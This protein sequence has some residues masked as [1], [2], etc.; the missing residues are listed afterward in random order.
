MSCAFRYYILELVC[1]SVLSVMSSEMEKIS[2]Q[3]K[4]EKYRIYNKKTKTKKKTK[5]KDKKQTIWFARYPIAIDF[6]KEEE[7]LHLQP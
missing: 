4:R 2:K 5:K 6:G 3:T 7:E 1:V